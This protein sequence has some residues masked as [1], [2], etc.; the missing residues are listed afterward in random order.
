MERINNDSKDTNP[1]EVNVIFN[2]PFEIGLRALIILSVSY[3]LKLDIQRL[4]YLDY[5]VL[6]TED[7]GLQGA[8]KSIHPATPHR[9]GEIVVRRK[10]M[11]A[12]LDMMYRKTLLEMVYDEDGI[13][14]VASELTVAFLNLIESDYCRLIHNN[15]NWVSQKFSTY[16]SGEMKQYMDDKLGTWGGEFIYEALVRSERD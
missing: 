2:S 1:S 14:Y 7:I 9:S 3:P 12:G 6:H 15:A 10:A 11:Q 13:S 16:S 4:I 8:P 5:L